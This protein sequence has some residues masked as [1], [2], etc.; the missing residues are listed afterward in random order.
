MSTLNI[1][2]SQKAN[3]AGTK[4]TTLALDGNLDNST[5]ANLQAQ[6]TTA[7]AAKPA[8]LIFDLAN[9]KYVTSSGIRLFFTAAKQQKLHAGRVS[10]VNLQPQIKEVFDI[11]GSLPDMSIFRDQ[12]ELDAYLLARQKTYES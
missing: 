5:V 11:M 2:L 4:E 8:Q 12:A 10:F 6:L 7:L 1:K 9:L 3:T